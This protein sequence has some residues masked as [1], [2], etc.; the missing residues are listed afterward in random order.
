[1]DWK[2]EAI[3]KLRQY[4]AKRQALANIP[5]EIALVESNMASIR[6]GRPD[7]V[8]VSGGSYC[9]G[10]KLLSCIVQKE[11]LERNLDRAK[12]WVEQVE[13]ALKV[14]DNDERKV[15]ERMYI[16]REKYAA[17]SLADELCI[18]VKTVY[19]R[20][21]KALHRFTV[22]LYGSVES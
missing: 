12:I 13:A 3:D 8:A 21:D 22:A 14:L 18:D 17:D 6:S 9:R 15:L 16:V 2:T 7:T 19:A 10:D 4:E 1:M 5:R 11:E 20:K